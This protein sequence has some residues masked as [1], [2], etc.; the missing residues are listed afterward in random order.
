MG[1]WRDLL[2]RG[3]LCA[4]LHRLLLAVAMELSHLPIPHAIK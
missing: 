2:V 4:E 1:E 3:R